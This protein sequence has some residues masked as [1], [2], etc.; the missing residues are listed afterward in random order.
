VSAGPQVEPQ[1]VDPAEPVAVNLDPAATTEP[2]P[3]SAPE[4]PAAGTPEPE[5]SDRAR[6]ELAAIDPAAVPVDRG[7]PLLNVANALT[8]L[9][10]LLVPVFAAITI[11]SDLSD[12]EWRIAATITF[13]IASITDYVDGWVARRHNLVT[14][15]GKVAD[16][17]ADKALTGTALVLLST[18][19]I[20]PWWMTGLILVRELGITALRFGVLRH[21]VIP[22]TPGGKLK[23]FLQS[24]AIGWLLLPLPPALAEIG[25]WVMYVATAVTVGTGIDYVVRAM[26][27]RRAAIQ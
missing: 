25:L 17:I 9:R 10:L 16:P 8:A 20:V 21:G 4:T 11:I 6:A 12:P 5:I 24:L 3:D 7:A 14:A 27:L 18:H 26:R 23:T 2:L 19:D 15:F 22:A 13:G 1:A